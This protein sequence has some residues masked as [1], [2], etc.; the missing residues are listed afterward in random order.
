MGWGES[1]R[2]MRRNRQGGGRERETGSKRDRHTE[3]KRFGDAHRSKPRHTETQKGK[4]PR[5]G[6]K[7]GDAE[8]EKGER[9]RETEAEGR[10]PEAV[11]EAG[12]L[13]SEAQAG[14]GSPRAGGGDCHP[15]P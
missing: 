6:M 12:N 13:L 11:K 10:E 14:A 9:C 8:T 4:R 7:V 2:E 1:K 3:A 15:H 5:E